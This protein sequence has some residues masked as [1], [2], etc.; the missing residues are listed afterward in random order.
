[1]RPW[2]RETKEAYL[3]LPLRAHG[4]LAD[5]PIHD[6]WR[7]HLAESGREPSSL[8]VRAVALA[9]LESGAV[10]PLVTALFRV[11]SWLG[12]LLGWDRPPAE[13][14]GP[15]RTAPPALEEASLIPPGT[16]DGPFR[17]MYVLPGEAASSIRN[18]TV[19]AYLV[20]AIRP[21]PTGHD[22]VWAIHVR[23]V[24][25]WTRPYLALIQPFRRLLVYPALLGAFYRA[26]AR[27]PSPAA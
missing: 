24:G 14:I 20:W 16:R 25:T 7:V 17:V 3:A 11:R 26:W 12:A 2:G 22:L 9:L 27:G 23:P 8:E 5:V 4:I 21:A 19:E 10:S 13:P 6:V 15:T 1:M 18:S